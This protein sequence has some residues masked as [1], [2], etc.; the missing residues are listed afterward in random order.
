M[1]GTHFVNTWNG[2]FSP[3]GHL[4]MSG[5]ILGCHHWGLLLASSGKRPV[6]CLNIPQGTGQHSPTPA[7][8][9]NYPSQ[10]VSSAKR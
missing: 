1:R 2:G 10:N 4:A 3:R 9:K 7:P 5:D 6:V 8:I